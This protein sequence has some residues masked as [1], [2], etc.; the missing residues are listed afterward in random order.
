MRFNSGPGWPSHVHKLQSNNMVWKKTLSAA[1]LIVVLLVKEAVK[2]V[3]NCCQAAGGVIGKVK[4]LKEPEKRFS[5]MNEF[6][7][8]VTD[9]IEEPDLLTDEQ[10]SRMVGQKGQRKKADESESTEGSSL[11]DDEEQSKPVEVTEAK[12]ATPV[13]TKKKHVEEPNLF[14]T[15]RKIIN[16]L[17]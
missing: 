9:D 17:V 7:K 8:L 11:F 1:G 2:A 14:G 4:R 3:V 10:I 5:D 13:E 15:E 16:G 6:M 12:P